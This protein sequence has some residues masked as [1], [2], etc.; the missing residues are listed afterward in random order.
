MKLTRMRLEY[1][2]PWPN[3]AGMFVARHQG[4]Y[5]EKGLDVDIVWDGWDRGTPVELTIAGEFQFASVRLGEL[6]ETRRTKNPFVAVATFN[7]NQL[8][9]VI[10]LKSK[11]IASFADLEGKVVS[12]PPAPRLV[13]M[14]RDAMTAAGADLDKVD[15]RN[16]RPFEPDIRA[17]ERGRYDAVFN[18]LGWEAYQGSTPFDE[19]VQ[20]SFDEVGVTPHHAYFLCVTETMAAEQPQMVRDFVQATARGYDFALAEPE[21]ALEMMSPTMCNVEPEALAASLAY[22]APTWHAPSGR[23]GEIQEP[24]L[25]S[26]T[27]WMIDGGFCSASLDDIPGAWTNEFLA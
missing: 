14:V 12:I 1:V 26:Y 19:V 18:V 10:S 22:M 21:A 9:G 4:W 25:Y 8:G 20:L 24:L 5:A 6:L 23:W 15:M 11:G 3:H 2:N 13:E 7:Q 27:K 17:V 16:P